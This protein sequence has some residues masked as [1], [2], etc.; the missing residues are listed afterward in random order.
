[1][2]LEH[3][4]GHKARILRVLQALYEHPSGYTK[5]QL[6]EKYGVSLDTISNDFTTIKNADFVITKDDNHRYKLVLNKRHK[7]LKELLHFSEED[8]ALLHQAIDQISPNSYRAKMLKKKLVALYDFKKLGHAY[9]RKPYLTKVDKLLQAQKEQ[10]QIILKDY[11]SSNSNVVSDRLVEGFY[12]NPPEDTLQTYDV[13]KKG[14]RHFRISR[15]KRVIITDDHWQH[16]GHHADRR[17]DPFRI[18]DN[19]QVTVSLT[20]KVG[21]RNELVER[22]PLTKSYIQPGDEPDTYDFQCLVN[23]HFL[24]LTNFILGYHHQ[25]IQINWPESLLVH[26]REKV[27]RMEF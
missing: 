5:R 4:Y 3:E 21:A 22:F 26:L 12:V 17:M 1:M 8:Q 9:L 19:E 18:V 23:H 16:K 10:K 27:E 24:G 11:P 6:A 13:D 2:A 7:Q 25:G 14:L 15:I 20:I